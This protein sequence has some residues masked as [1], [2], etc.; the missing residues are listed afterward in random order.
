MLV[1]HGESLRGARARRGDPCGDATGVGAMKTRSIARRVV[2]WALVVILVIG[3]SAPES[4]EAQARDLASPF[5]DAP[6]AR[7]RTELPPSPGPGHVPV[8]LEADES[9]RMIVR[10]RRRGQIEDVCEA[11]CAR[12]L[13]EGG[14][15]LG[16]GDAIGARWWSGPIRLT[17]PTTIEL[18]YVDNALTRGIGWIVLAA[19]LITLGASAYDF[20]DD[21]VSMGSVDVPIATSILAAVALGVSF[22]LFFVSDGVDFRVQ[23]GITQE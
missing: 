4:T 10:E 11:P 1:P 13:A 14:L 17:E 18:H 19:S 9:R 16:V 15:R 8:V 23:P 12:W 2:G 21:A 3:A 6:R 22:G 5:R 20:L 7:S